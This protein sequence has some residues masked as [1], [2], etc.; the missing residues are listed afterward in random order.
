[1]DKLI[2][3]LVCNDRLGWVS[4]DE[5]L[6]YLYNIMHFLPGMWAF[7]APMKDDN[8]DMGDEQLF[9]TLSYSWSEEDRQKRFKRQYPY[10]LLNGFL[11]IL[12]D[13]PIEKCE[14]NGI[15]TR[16]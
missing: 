10:T 3:T 15:E 16:H 9:L 1:M 13:S 11:R 2:N 6:P 5:N 4:F 8:V 14:E 7:L 12:T